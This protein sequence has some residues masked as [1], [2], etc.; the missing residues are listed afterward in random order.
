M[1]VQSDL[2]RYVYLIEFRVNWDGV[3]SQGP[4][5]PPIYP[6]DAN[7]RTARRGSAPKVFPVSS[8]RDTT[9]AM[10]NVP[11]AGGV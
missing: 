8:L 7:F 4:V 10:R 1:W 9:R 5:D 6:R 2:V 11:L 3:K